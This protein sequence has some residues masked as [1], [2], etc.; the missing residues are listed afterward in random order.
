M[1]KGVVTILKFILILLFLVC[2]LDMPYSYFQ[3][4]RI[5]GMIGFA[6]IAY[7]EKQKGNERLAIFWGLSAIIINPIFKVSL[8][9]FL[10]NIIDLIWAT[11]LSLTLINDRKKHS[12]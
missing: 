11:I 3:F 9:R 4:V 8:G 6:I 5:I 1:S 2:W 7:D 12:I 10:W